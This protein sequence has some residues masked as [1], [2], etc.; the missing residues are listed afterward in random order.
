MIQYL[1]SFYL[2]CMC[3]CCPSFLDFVKSDYYIIPLGAYVIYGLHHMCLPGGLDLAWK[4]LCWFVDFL[5]NILN[6]EIYIFTVLR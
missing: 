6:L 4:A 3:A 5:I 1:Q 2:F